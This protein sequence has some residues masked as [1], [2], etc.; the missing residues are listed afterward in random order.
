M[1]EKNGTEVCVK[2]IK[3]DKSVSSC[4]GHLAGMNLQM[5]YSSVNT[6]QIQA[7]LCTLKVQEDVQLAISTFCLSLKDCWSQTYF[8][9]F[10]IKGDCYEKSCFTFWSENF[11]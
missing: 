7:K 1:M 11:N 9:D 8:K 2:S 5:Y 10:K 4:H 3:I 6:C